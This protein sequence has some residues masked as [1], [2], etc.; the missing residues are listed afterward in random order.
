MKTIG[1]LGGIGP[2]ATMDFENKLHLAAQSLIPQN[3]N[4]GYPKM[5]TYYFRQAPF[6]RAKNGKAEVP[7][8]P[9]PELLKAA[10]ELGS[11]CDFLVIPSNTPHFF[12]EEIEQAAGKKPLSIVEEAFKEVRRRG[13]KKIGVLS[14]GLA[15]KHKLYEKMLEGQG[16]T[17]LTIEQDMSA[18]L[19][20]FVFS[21]MEGKFS[22]EA[23]DCALNCLDYIRNQGA[24]ATIIGCTEIPLLL[25]KKYS[26]AQDL[27]NP[28]Q[29]LA[30]AAIKFAIS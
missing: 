6:L 1:I 4:E 28:A 26:E 25:G 10:A 19:D 29:L 17:W 23:H 5:V 20:E 12:L 11:L 14:V 2:Q 13:V 24:E 3:A 22:Q 8:K 7:I 27:I 21:Y 9:N 16:L 30:E 15:F 18:R